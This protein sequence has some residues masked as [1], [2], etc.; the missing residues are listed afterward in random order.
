MTFAIFIVLTLG[1]FIGLLNILP[2]I[3][4]FSFDATSPVIMVIGY[5]KSW[6][7]L[8]PIK[9]LL[10]L[11]TAFIIF[12][13]SIWVWHVMWRVVKFLRGHSDGS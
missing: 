3:T 6:D 13:L 1:V 9:E 5:M 7:F 11:V 12:E 4:A 8:F 10:T 2:P